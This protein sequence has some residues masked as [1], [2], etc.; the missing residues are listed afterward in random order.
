MQYIIITYW[1][2]MLKNNSG[3]FQCPLPNTTFSSL[4]VSWNCWV[5]VQIAQ[6]W[7]KEENV[8]VVQS[9]TCVWLCDP[10]D[11]SPPGSSVLHYVPEFAQ[12]H[13]HQVGDAA[14]HLILCCVPLL[15]PSVFP[16]IRSFPMSWLFASGGQ[17]IGT[18]G[19]T[20]VLPMN[21]QD[22]FL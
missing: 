11:C 18:S 12:T 22:L 21:T 3:P 15:L 4:N 20:S 14:N 7:I 2:V 9:L 19:S 16:S 13:V 10:M 6:L 1:F 17:S 5:L 8:A